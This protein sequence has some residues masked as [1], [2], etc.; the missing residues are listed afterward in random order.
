MQ[1]VF[2]QFLKESIMLK[3]IYIFIAIIALILSAPVWASGSDDNLQFDQNVTPDVIFGSGNGNGAFTTVRTN[4]LEVGLRAKLRFPVPMGVY[5]SNGDG[6][7]SFDAGAACPGF[8]WV[9]FP[10]CLTTPVWSFEWSVN[11]DYDGSSGMVVSDYV[12]ELGLDADPGETADFT[13]FDPITPSFVA[14]AFDH[15]IGNNATPN[16][17]GTSDLLNYLSLISTN[18]VVQNSW[19][20]EFFNNLGTSLASFDPSV[21][22]TYDLYLMVSDAVTGE[23]V[24]TTR[25][26]II[27]GT[28]AADD[29]SDDSSDDRSDDSSD[30]GSD[31]SSGDD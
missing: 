15:A 2:S 13:V 19:N 17:G 8:S 7:Y 5:N 4:G 3:Q 24:A 30:D 14:P 9:P 12:Y 1:I 16:G 11:T 27:V 23:H 10:L 6:T 22:G 28:G 26:Q 31:D 20:Y 29:E 18:N 25:I 21:N